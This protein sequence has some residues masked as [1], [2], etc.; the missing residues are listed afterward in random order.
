[1][2]EER[3]QI[4]KMLEEGKITA[5][6]AAELLAAVEKPQAESSPEAL[7]GRWMRV[8]VTDLSTGKKK[9]NVTVPLAMVDVAVRMG[10]RFAPKSTSFDPQEVLDAVRVGDKGKILDVED[11]EDGERVEIFID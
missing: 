5:K 2:S 3:I 8:L 11:E 6:E 9:I 4:L 10:A 1:V 7:R